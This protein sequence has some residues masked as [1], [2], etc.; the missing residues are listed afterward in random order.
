[1]TNYRVGTYS[2]GIKYDDLL[3]GESVKVS[4][5]N[6]RLANGEGVER[7]TLISRG[8]DGYYRVVST[9]DDTK[10]L[11]ISAMDSATDGNRVILAYYTGIFNRSKIKLGTGLNIGDFEDKMKEQ[12]LY[13]TEIDEFV[14]WNPINYG[15][16]EGSDDGSEIGSDEGSSTG[17]NVTG[18]E[19]E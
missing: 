4:R 13:L 6:V 10:L 16:E 1:M 8:N 17:S 19:A 5:V 7:G 14:E 2:S 15:S 18:S 11:A 12:G 3:G 9:T